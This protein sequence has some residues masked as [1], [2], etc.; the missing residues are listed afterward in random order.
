MRNPNDAPCLKCG[1]R[2]IGCHTTC[3][4]FAAY[5]IRMQELGRRNREEGK[6]RGEF[7]TRLE[8]IKRLEGRKR[9]TKP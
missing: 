9:R 5:R 6:A 7:Y 3:S 2:R 4:R 8:R 1:D